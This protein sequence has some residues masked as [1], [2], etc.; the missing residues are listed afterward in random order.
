MNTLI[1]GADGM[2]G[3]NLVRL[4]LKRGHTVTAFL[5][6]SS[7]STT[8]DG[9]NIKKV[10]GDLIDE[11]AL[12]SAIANIDV[13]I[14]AAASTSIWPARSEY[15]KKVNIDGTQNVISA[16]LKHKIGKL[17]YVGSASSV[18]T[19]K[20]AK[21]KFAFPGEKFGLDYIDSKYEAFKLV[22]NS[23]EKD[24]LPAT[25]I[26]PTYMIGAYDSLPGSGKM[27]TNFANGKLKFFTKGGRNFIHAK[28]VAMAIA[29]SIDSKYDGKYFIAGN[30]NLSYKSFFKKVAAVINKKELKTKVP[31]WL[32]LAVGVLGS[33]YGKIVKR[34]PLITYQMARISY[35]NQFVNCGGALEELQ[36]KPTPVKNAIRDSYNWF[37]EN[38]Y[39]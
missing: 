32:V 1:T 35:E 34:Q 7:K 11:N 25:V 16:V 36:V 28:D 30:E 17:I 6:P 33:A 2:L 8:L 13:L 24:N 38:N 18:H 9:L 29:N 31:S 19:V 20:N 21:S 10:Y 5:H 37:T 4:L 39:C 3:S 14:H 23:I 26:L 27:I 22:M 12:D 15:V